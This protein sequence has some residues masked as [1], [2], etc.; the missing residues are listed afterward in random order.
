MKQILF[1]ILGTSILNVFTFVLYQGFV[2]S[3][4]GRQ[5]REEITRWFDSMSK[6]MQKQKANNK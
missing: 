5:A 4:F 1:T 3:Y 6:H 2:Q